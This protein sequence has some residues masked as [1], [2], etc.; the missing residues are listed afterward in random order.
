[1]NSTP[2]T[3]PFGLARR[4]AALF[5]LVAAAL[6]ALTIY[7][8]RDVE[9]MHVTLD[10]LSEEQRETDASMYLLHHVRMLDVHSRKIPLSS[11]G[12]HDEALAELEFH[13]AEARKTLADLSGG[14]EGPDPSSSEHAHDEARL[15]GELER[16]SG[17]L[18]EQLTQ[19]AAPEVVLASVADLL[20]AAEVLNDEVHSEELQAA[21]E[22]SRRADELRSAVMFAALMALSV[23]VGVLV[24]VQRSV[25][26][27]LLELRA[28]A[29]RFAAGELG[30]RV[31][32]RTSDEVGELAGEF[33][34]MASELA[35]V[36]SELERRV[37]Q[38]TAEFLRAARLAGLGTMAAGIAHEINN[39]L[40]SIAS[41]AEGLERR[42]RAGQAD[43][44]EQREYLG[45]IAKEAYR[46]HEITSR[47]LEFARSNPGPSTSFHAADVLR[48]LEPLVRHRLL[49]RE[50]SLS[51]ECDEQ[52][53]PLHGRPDECKQ[54]VLNLVHNAIDASPR[55]GRI[56]VRCRAQDE[57][58]TLEVEDQ[59]PGL[60]PQ[61]AE[62]AF[63]PFFTTKPPG[64]GTGLG[65]SIVDR[66]VASHGGRVEIARGREGALFRVVLPQPEAALL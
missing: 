43:A 20:R 65:L 6:V 26:R 46:A 64:Q 53:P 21:A 14:P 13:T 63:D 54:V 42:L 58:F 23:L 33:N 17:L 41:C 66:I 15:Y 5:A 36:Q 49:E 1:M 18:Y 39:P 25:V 22:L 44:Q 62:R 7:V 12:A 40:A 50:L 60:D 19:A 31:A 51:V 29:R 38:R 56:W 47:L 48:D 9:R 27:P 59:G 32:A 2:R 24:L 8:T 11:W 35:G 45:I 4:V 3:L 16:A 10:R 55:G 52:L 57:G 37:E 34:R 28:G 30:H 61:V